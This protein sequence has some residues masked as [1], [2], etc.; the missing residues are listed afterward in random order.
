VATNDLGIMDVKPPSAGDAPPSGTGK[1][2]PPV[3]EVEG[4]EQ[5]QGFGLKTEVLPGLT[6]LAMVKI[7]R[8]CWRHYVMTPRR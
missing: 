4:Q 3:K 1:V 5:P 8:K 2:K 7:A 6:P